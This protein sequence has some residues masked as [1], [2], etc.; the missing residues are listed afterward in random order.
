MAQELITAPL[1]AF[2]LAAAGVA[3]L[4]GAAGL[5]PRAVP[6]A[7]SL[8]ARPVPRAGG[9][10][11]WRGFLPAALLFAPAFPGGVAGWL[12]PMLALI[13]V[14]GWDDAKELGVAARLS[15]QGS[16][17]LWVSASLDLARKPNKNKEVA[18]AL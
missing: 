12:P 6:N 7:R 4:R 8:H 15:V 11:I 16:S 3:L 1:L 2:V 18:H 5:L 13:A 14:S 9:Y 17:A 10:A